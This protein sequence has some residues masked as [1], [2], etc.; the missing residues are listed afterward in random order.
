[1]VRIGNLVQLP[2]V[3]E[4]RNPGLS[5]NGDDQKTCKRSRLD[6]DGSRE[7]VRFQTGLRHSSRLVFSPQIS[8]RAQK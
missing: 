1:V 7:I 6:H 8:K 3:L 4:V 5:V 2:A